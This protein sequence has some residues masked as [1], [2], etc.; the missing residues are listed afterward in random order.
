MYDWMLCHKL[1]W[2]LFI[3]ALRSTG[4]PPKDDKDGPQ[5]V[6]TTRNPFL[7]VLLFGDFFLY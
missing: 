7:L 2:G 3:T 5:P 1:P 4:H 6:P